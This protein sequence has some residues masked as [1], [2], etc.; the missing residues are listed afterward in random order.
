MELRPYQTRAIRATFDALREH[1]S[2]ILQLPTGAGKTFCATSIARIAKGRRFLFCVD[3]LTLLDQAS[4]AF[5]RDGQSV[6]IIQGDTPMNLAAK[7]QVASIQTLAS[8]DFWPDVNCVFVDEAHAQY[9]IVKEAM[10]A[11]PDVKFIGLTATPWTTGLGNT[12]DTLV[13]GSTVKELMGLGYL[14]PYRAYGP[15]QPDLKGCKSTGGDYA[16]SDLDPRVRKIFGDVLQSYETLGEGRKALCFTVNVAHAKE[17]ALMFEGRGIPADYVCG[18]DE[19]DRRRRVLKD[20][21]EGKIRILFNVDVLTKGYDQP[22]IGCVILARPTRSLSLHIQM[23]G[24]GLRTAPGKDD[25]IF[26]DHG[27][28]I[29]RLGFPDDDLPAELC[30]K[31]KGVSS[32]DRREKDDPLPW[33]CGKCHHVNPVDEPACTVCGHVRRRPSRVE[34]TEEKL[35]RLTGRADKQETYSQLLCIATDRGYSRGWAAHKYRELWGVW[36]R[37]LQDT[38]MVPTPKMRAWVTSQQIRYAKRKERQHA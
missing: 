18:R 1:Q 34:S 17:L 38:L 36:P 22:D 6:G 27:G 16:K 20:Y 21:A 13:V 9:A 30:T 37:G 5:A 2:V 31:E 15:S 12:W 7:I 26:I 35:V 11:N 29:E 8:R 4:T 24:R 19:D 3:R 25:C 32:T 14:S 10:Q 33:N 28:N 23:L